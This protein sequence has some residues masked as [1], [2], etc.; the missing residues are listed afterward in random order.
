MKVK[1][2]IDTQTFVR[3]WLV[4]IGFALALLMIYKALTGLIIVGVALFLALALNEPVSRLAR[5]LPSKSRVF[6]TAISYVLIIVV[7]GTFVFLAVPPVVQQTARFA[8]TVPS[9]VNQATTSWHALD[10]TINKYNL[11]P[12][13]DGTLAHLKDSA[14]KFASNAGATIL[15]S[16]GSIASFITGTVLVLVLS[17]LMLIEGPMWM[18]RIWGL[19]DND[20]LMERHRNMVQKMHTVVSGYV[21]GQLTVSAIGS[22]FAGIA[23]FILSIFF[24]YPANLAI[25]AVAITFIFSLI[26]MFGALIG[27]I[28]VAILLGINVIGAA[29]AYL[30]YFSIYQQIENNLIAPA[31][32]AKRLELSALAILVSVTIGLYLFGIIGG[33]VSIPIAGIIKVLLEDHLE[34]ARRAQKQQEGPIQRLVKKTIANRD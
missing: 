12:Q 21:I 23:V 17:I 11:R 19:Y 34:H 1:I 7:L 24:H 5:H 18:K 10:R 31:I 29:L 27:G 28:V 3:F 4:V 9:L 32:Q 26:P 22:T 30:V 14:S 6:S 20:K 33:L 2:Q 25:P 8:E 13:V 15:S 16:L